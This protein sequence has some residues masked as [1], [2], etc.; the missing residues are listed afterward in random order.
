[1]RNGRNSI[2]L[3]AALAFLFVV[4]CSLE[5]K[6]QDTA[7]DNG[8][9]LI[10]VKDNTRDYNLNW[11]PEDVS[12]DIQSYLIIGNGPGE[13]TFEETIGTDENK[14]VIP[15]LRKGSWS[16]TIYGLNDTGLI[17]GEGTSTVDVIAGKTNLV[18][19]S[20]K[21]IAGEGTLVVAIEWPVK[22]VDDPHILLKLTKSTGE[23]PTYHTLTPE[24]PAVGM[25]SRSL[26]LEA[27]FYEV[28]VKI[29]DGSP[30][31]ESNKLTG[32]NGTARI[33][34]E[35]TTNGTFTFTETHLRV[36]G[37]VEI[38][39]SNDMPVPFTVGL[40]QDRETTWDGQPITFDAEVSLEGGYT[41]T[42]YL[43]GDKLEG[44]NQSRLV[45]DPS[46]LGYGMHFLGVTVAKAGVLSSAQTSFIKEDAPDRYF[47]MKL[48]EPGTD[49]LI[50]RFEFVTNVSY[51]H[52]DSERDI[53]LYEW[54]PLQFSNVVNTYQ[55]RVIDETFSL[56]AASKEIDEEIWPN[57]MV[58]GI[59]IGDHK[60]VG[61]YPLSSLGSTEPLLLFFYQTDIFPVADDYIWAD[62]HSAMD[63]TGGNITI[64]KFGDIGDY[65]KGF[66]QIDDAP[67]ILYYDRIDDDGEESTKKEIVSYDL[68]VDFS[69]KRMEDVVLTFHKVTYMMDESTILKEIY[70]LAD[71]EV[72]LDSA[73]DFEND[74]EPAG[75]ALIG[76]STEPDGSGKTYAVGSHTNMPSHDLTLFPIWEKLNYAVG[77][78]GP[79][80]GYVFYDKGYYSDDWRYLE[81][82][83]SGWSGNSRDPKYS[84]G[85]H[86]DGEN[87]LFLG[88]EPDIGRGYNNTILLISSMGDKAFSMDNGDDKIDYAAKIASS[89]QEGESNS[90]YG[91]WFLPSKDE[92]NLMFTN[93]HEQGLG[94]FNGLAYR[95]W[96]S[97][98]VNSDYAWSQSFLD[99]DQGDQGHS[100]RWSETEH[101]VRPIR[102]F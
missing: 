59:I 97:T 9:L 101:S 16:I 17:V 26:D 43:D 42:W 61:T 41:L 1:M 77:D 76:W 31:D 37:D 53:E 63:D 94:N 4:G 30:E 5:M 34:K 40:V 87:R 54:A 85:F 95:Y 73:S 39:I 3:L 14:K 80:G 88:T 35:I 89:Y 74:I 46:E 78:I 27:G 13:R 50:H 23:S 81:A 55:K 51:E 33:L 22:E 96:S 56:L 47:V 8:I 102:A 57:L 60:G 44:E 49:N 75:Y 99:G 62:L 58:T 7:D 92:L 72:Y 65:I 21:S 6:I 91:D 24:D 86:R 90:L 36:F 18:N 45:L 82:A 32:V 84:F 11:E 38:T 66:V 68:R 70:K 83:P 20:V 52:Y 15:N 79:S 71:N 19:V 93:L 69:L 100:K 12:P 25:A 29:Y 2:I 98:E 10:Q 64:S 28:T 48:F 67:I